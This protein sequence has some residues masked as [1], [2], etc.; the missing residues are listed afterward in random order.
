VTEAPVARKLRVMEV[1]S[2]PFAPVMRTT[3]FF[4]IFSALIQEA[5]ANLRRRED[6][7]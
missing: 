3:L 6:E 4:M 1:P 5:P 2:P 7:P